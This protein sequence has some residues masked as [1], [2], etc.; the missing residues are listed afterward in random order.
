MA[1]DLDRIVNQYIDMIIEKNRYATM[2][3]PKH[4]QNN[5]N[6]I[7]SIILFPCYYQSEPETHNH[8]K[9]NVL[10]KGIQEDE[11]KEENA[12]HIVK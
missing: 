2:D 11:N 9:I 12:I 10:L 5:N 7:E 6:N 3:H 8:K 4:T 1:D